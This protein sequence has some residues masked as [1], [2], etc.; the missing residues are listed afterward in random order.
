MLGIARS[1]TADEA[2][3][4][5]VSVLEAVLLDEVLIDRLR[6]APDRDLRLDPFP[7]R[8]TGRAGR[9]RRPSRWPGW[10]IF[11]PQV[12]RTGGDGY[13]KPGVAADRLAIDARASMDLVLALA[14]RQNGLDHNPQ[15]RL[16]DVQLLAP[17]KREQRKP[18]ADKVALRLNRRLRKTY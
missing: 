11:A 14:A 12:P 7:M 18:P 5:V 17:D 2:L 16:Q 9:L 8:L 6:I 15:M 13:L 10:G 4:G 1:Q 3:D